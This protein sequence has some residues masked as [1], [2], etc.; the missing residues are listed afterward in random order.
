MTDRDDD[1]LRAALEAEADGVTA[2]E[3]LL[4]RVRA[5]AASGGSSQRR[6]APW[7]LVAAVAVIVGLAAALLLGGDDDQTLDV[8]DDPTTTTAPSEP[9]TTTTTPVTATQRPTQAVAVTPQGHVVVLDT[10]T[11]AVLRDLGGYDDPTDPAVAEREGGPY[12]I[13]RVALHPNGRDVY[14]ETCCE[15]ASGAILRLP[16]DGS[17]RID[18]ANLEPVAYGYGLDLSADGRWLASVNEQGVT[19]TDLETGEQITST[20]SA[21]TSDLVRAAVNHDGT[22]VTVE[23]ALQYDP[24]NKPFYVMRSELLTFRRVGDALEQ[25]DRTGGDVRLLPVY[26]NGGTELVTKAT[27]DGV[28]DLTVDRTGTWFLATPYEMPLRGYTRA[29]D[30]QEIPGSYL[31]ADW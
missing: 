9:T 31:S 7:L 24:D 29:D 21:E 26:A 20:A 23:R 12:S 22:E 10:A 11:G 18:D 5:R 2:G 25:T 6:G 19:L 14:V 30:E 8:V 4:D 1:L 28:I 27:R 13:T 17:V 16:I 15:P 3:E